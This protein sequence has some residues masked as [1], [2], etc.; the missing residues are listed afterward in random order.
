MSA[1]GWIPK[2]VP[3]GGGE[4]DENTANLGEP[5][6]TYCQNGEFG[7]HGGVR[8]RPSAQRITGF[9]KRGLDG[10][11]K[12]TDTALATRAAT[13]YTSVATFP[14]RDGNGERA[15][16]LTQGRLFTRESDR[17]QD[18]LGALSATY[19]R[20]ADT[21]RQTEWVNSAIGD[22]LVGPWARAFG[23]SHGGI[24]S[25]TNK[26][27]AFLGLRPDNTQGDVQVTGAGSTNAGPGTGA[28][29]SG[30]EAVVFV[31]ATT[32]NL[33]MVLRSAGSYALSTVTL[34]TDAATPAGFGDAPCVCCDFDETV[35]FVVYRTT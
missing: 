28:V 12:P 30:T 16:L 23:G 31:E 14:V 21:V 24:S 33:K 11:D 18:R 3:L 35:F 19:R 17:W 26:T 20:A 2:I 15:A 22:L 4:H 10:G 5:S 9:S 7:I 34:K 8:P 27:Y 25:A 1:R 29:C 6:V 13:G 32:N